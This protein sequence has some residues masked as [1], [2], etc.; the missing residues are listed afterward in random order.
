VILPPRWHPL[1]RSFLFLLA[2]FGVQVLASA[3]LQPLVRTLGGTAMPRGAQALLS[4]VLTAPLLVPVTL[5]FLRALDRRDLASLGVR[6][7]VGGWPAAWRQ[8]ARV[9]LVVLGLLAAWLALLVLLP[10]V[11]VRFGGRSGELAGPSGLAGLAGLLAAFL[12]QGGVE[13]WVFRGYIY[14][15]LRERWRRGAAVLVSSLLF[16]ALHAAN[17]DFSGTALVNTFLAGAIFALLVERSGSLWS[18][19]LAHGVWNFAVSCLLSLP[20]SGVSLPHLLVLSVRGPDL[21]TGGGF[22]PEGSLLLTLLALPLALFRPL[23]RRP[24]QEIAVSTAEDDP[25]PPPLGDRRGPGLA[26]SIETTESEQEE[27]PA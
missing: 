23:P 18:A 24:L 4:F 25:P 7:P 5:F 1:V 27:E 20:V 13:E 10:A 9:P 19:T 11:A 2:V 21:L 17:P 22:G 14:R 12:I 26:K 15:A 3:F 6:W 16:A 8:A